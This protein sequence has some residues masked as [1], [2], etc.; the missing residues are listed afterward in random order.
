MKDTPPTAV[1]AASALL[2]AYG[3]LSL[4]RIWLFGSGAPGSIGSVV[5][6]CAALAALA[7]IAGSL[8]MGRQWA[9]W[10]LTVAVG[11]AVLVFPFQIPE[12]PE[13]P[14][15]GIYILQILMPIVAAA[16]TFTPRAKAWF[17]G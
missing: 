4:L 17:R 16:L 15:L 13:G 6:W 8:Y 9:R 7:F 1:A 3:I 14:Q 10:V 5:V 2:V 12:M 11:L